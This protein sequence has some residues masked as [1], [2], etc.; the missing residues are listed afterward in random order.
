MQ[1]RFSAG[2]TISEKEKK[3]KSEGGLTMCVA[4]ASGS[5]LSLIA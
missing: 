1:K 5:K 3:K 2:V 4:T